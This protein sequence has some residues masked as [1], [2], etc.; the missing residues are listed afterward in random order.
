MVHRQQ[1]PLG[2]TME[3]RAFRRL[4]KLLGRH[5]PAERTVRKPAARLC[6]EP[7][8]S[9][10]VP[11]GTPELLKNVNPGTLGS[12]PGQITAVGDTIFFAARDNNHGRE[13]WK[14]DGTAAGTALVKDI[15]PGRGSS[16]PEYLTNF[17]GT[18]FFVAND[19]SNGTELWK[20]DGTAA[21]TVLVKDIRPGRGGSYPFNLTVIGSTLF[22]TAN[23]GV[24]GAELWKSD[25]TTAGT[26]LVKDIRPGRASSYPQN[27]TVVNGT[28]FFT[29]NDGTTGVELWKSDGTVAGTVLVKDIRPGNSPYGFPLSSSPSNL[30]A[31]GGQLFFSANDGTT[32][33]ELWKS[34]GTAAGTVL[35]KDIRPGSSYGSPASSSPDELTVV[36]DQLFFSANDGTNGEELWKSDGTPA[37]TVLVKDIRPGSSYGSPASSNP[38]RLAAAGARL[39]F[40][41]NDGANGQELW[42]SDGTAAGTVLVKDIRPGSSYGSPASSNPYELTAVGGKVFF[43]A[44][45]GVNGDELWRP[46]G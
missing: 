10:V 19:G 22:F 6:L 9:R 29:A 25:G 42:K 41:A 21:G 18:L 40:A 2:A 46:D 37:G 30:T 26:V 11:S 44:N 4:G 31:V 38:A 43:S 1:V 39:C 20:S 8:E 16:Y 45:D 13:L 14:T 12:S 17:N 3:L 36:G 23:D 5:M 28:L 15:N 27:H 24:N 33:R 32:G 7:L 35:V 34:D